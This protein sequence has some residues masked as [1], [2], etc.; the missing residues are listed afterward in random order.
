MRLKLRLLVLMNVMMWIFAAALMAQSVTAVRSI[1]DIVDSTVTVTITVDVDE[2]NAPTAI[3]LNEYIPSDWNVNV[4]SISP[5]ERDL[6]DGRIINWLFIDNV[7]DMTITY[8]LSVPAGDNGK[9]TFN[10]ELKYNEDGIDTT[11]IIGGETTAY[12]NN[13]PTVPQ[14]VYPE[15]GQTDLDS[16]IE[17]K[18][19][20]STDAEG[21]AVTYDLTVCADDKFKTVCFNNKEEIALHEKKPIFFAG[22]GLGLLLFGIVFAGSKGERFSMSKKHAVLYAIIIVIA[23]AGLI[24]CGSGGGGNDENPQ[25]PVDYGVSYRLAGFEGGATYFWKVI[26]YDEEGGQTESE[27]RSFTTGI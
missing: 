15:D 16:N 7:E 27:V 1:S 13:P 5:D 17:F 24:G 4:D 3:I 21:G 23:L 20:K 2:A 22:S 9:K 14:L 8:N 19:S 18:W 25:T 26:A 6:D 12:G 10:G 11:E